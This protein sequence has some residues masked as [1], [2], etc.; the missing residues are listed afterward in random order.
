MKVKE[1]TE[2][3]ALLFSHFCNSLE[4]MM[5]IEVRRHT[6]KNESYEVKRMENVARAFVEAVVRRS[7]QRF[8][9]RKG[10]DKESLQIF[11]NLFGLRA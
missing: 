7:A 8:T 5:H 4:E 3:E 1:R 6:R 11:C 10:Y 2:T 9:A